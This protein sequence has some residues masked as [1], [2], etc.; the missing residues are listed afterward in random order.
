MER[1]EIELLVVPDCANEELAGDLVR[2]AMA[3]LHLT[4]ATVRTTIIDTDDEAARRGFKG[5][6]TFLIDGRDP[7]ASGDAPPGLACRIYPTAEGLRG[8]P[9][10]RDLRQALKVAAASHRS[11]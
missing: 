2:T 4:A 6:P 7:F 1:V 5:S 8:V 3:D 11:H 10:I 9:D